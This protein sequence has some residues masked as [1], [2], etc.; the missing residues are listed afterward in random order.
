MSENKPF[1]L[2]IKLQFD[3]LDD[4]VEGFAR[5]VS[6]GGLFIPI[7]EDRHQPVATVVRFQF[8]LSDGSTAL[9]GE[10]TIKQLQLPPSPRVGMLIKFKKLSRS[11]Q[12]IVRQ[13]VAHKKSKSH[14]LSISGDGLSGSTSF[15]RA[16]QDTTSRHDPV[17]PSMLQPPTPERDNPTPFQLDAVEH[18]ARSKEQENSDSLGD[19]ATRAHDNPELV[20]A[21]LQ[22]PT[23]ESHASPV[24]LESDEPSEK[25]AS[26]TPPPPMISE[27]FPPT[28]QDLPGAEELG[29]ELPIAPAPVSEQGAY[30]APLPTPPPAPVMDQVPADTKEEEKKTFTFDDDFDLDLNSIMSEAVLS[31]AS[32]SPP[33]LQ[34]A[35]QTVAHTEGG[36]HVMAYNKDSD[37]G[38]ESM[39]LAAF[40]MA[41]EEDDIDG[42][43][44]GLFG[45]NDVDDAFE[46]MFT[47]DEPEDEAIP[48]APEES[49]EVKS[50]A[51]EPSAEL[52]SLLGAF[53]GEHTP[54]E[55]HSSPMLSLGGIEEAKAPQP[56][57]EEESLEDLL[58]LA[59]KDIE[60]NSKK[61]DDDLL[62]QLLG[63]SANIPNITPDDVPMLPTP[64]NVENQGKKKRGLFSSLFNK[65]GS[66]S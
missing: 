38:E 27:D 6:A 41:E 15:A 26:T 23:P 48:E 56:I 60:D 7:S 61:E 58:A 25:D 55:E 16:D 4:F 28:Y 2:R 65:K 47:Q 45:G 54:E 43:F 66:D 13:I 51:P 63:D 17:S 31:P 37:L 52:E 20:A 18:I 34:I 3:T 8:L 29:I 40:S 24:A 59:R 36:L 57:E 35:P 9:L 50:E 32:L 44:E 11:S 33:I 19:M 39:G 49:L 30:E 12:D 53:D 21:A 62:G 42:L 46:E 14:A 5:Y 1:K 10:G 22:P 64:P